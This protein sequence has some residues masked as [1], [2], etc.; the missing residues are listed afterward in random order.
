MGQRSGRVT[1]F[2]DHS[3]CWEENRYV[4]P[5][6]SRRS[7]GLSL[8]INLNPDGACN[9][10]CIYCQ[11]DRTVRSAVGKVDPARV[12]LELDRAIASAMDGGLVEHPRFARLKKIGAG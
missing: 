6:I 7:R 3:R 5:V 8:G 10:D 1:F 2:A 9:F 11:V 12:A 4:Y